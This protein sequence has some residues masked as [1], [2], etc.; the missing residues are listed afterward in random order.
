LELHKKMILLFIWKIN[1]Q[2]E[3]RTIWKQEIPGFRIYYKN[4][5][6]WSVSGDW[7]D[8]TAVKVPS[9][10]KEFKTLHSKTMS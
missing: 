6:V 1:K 5:C 7:G 9:Y 3:L 4:W 10:T 2:E 8:R